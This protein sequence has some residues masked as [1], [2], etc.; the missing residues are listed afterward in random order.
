MLTISEGVKTN[1]VVTLTEKV[2]ITDPYFLF[3]FTHI[4]TKTV[5]NIIK[6]SADDL[7]A[8]PDR[9]NEFVIDG[10]LFAH[11]GQWLYQVYEQESNTN[12]DTTGLSEVENGKADVVPSTS[13]S[14]K[15]YQPATA[16]KA[17]AG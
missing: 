4:T 14:Y 13:F 2:T 12:T 10:S 8:F 17:Y 3:V 5:V 16:Y 6:S 7:S 15:K 9:Y 1:V 11:T